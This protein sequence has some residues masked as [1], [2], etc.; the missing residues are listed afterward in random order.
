MMGTGQLCR[1]LCSE[2]SLGRKGVAWIGL[3]GVAG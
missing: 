1:S 2:P 3:E